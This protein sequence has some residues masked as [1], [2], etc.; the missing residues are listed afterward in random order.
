MWTREVIQDFFCFPCTWVTHL[1]L[2]NLNSICFNKFMCTHSETWIHKTRPWQAHEVHYSIPVFVTTTSICSKFAAISQRYSQVHFFTKYLFI[3][4]PANHLSIIFYLSITSI[5][6]SYNIRCSNTL[7]CQGKGEARIVFFKNILLIMFT[8]L[9]VSQIHYCNMQSWLLN[10]K[11][12][13]WRFS[14]P[15]S[16][17][18]QKKKTFACRY[19]NA[20]KK[21]SFLMI[22]FVRIFQTIIYYSLKKNKAQRFFL[23]SDCWELCSSCEVLSFYLDCLFFYQ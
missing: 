1:E 11:I 15:A 7:S 4:N 8:Q 14:Q 19:S 10:I 2:W 22:N 9:N 20:A 6:N 21:L 17:I 12:N 18:K 13:S 23:L 5:N 16:L 3:T